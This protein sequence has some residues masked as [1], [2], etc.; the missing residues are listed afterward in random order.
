MRREHLGYP[1]HPNR[2]SAVTTA[3]Q[4][5]LDSLFPLVFATGR[6]RCHH[7]RRPG[8]ATTAGPN[9]KGRQSPQTE[10]TDTGED[11]CRRRVRL[12]LGRRSAL[13][14]GSWEKHHAVCR[15]PLQT[16][17]R[18]ACAPDVPLSTLAL[19]K[20]SSLSSRSETASSSASRQRPNTTNPSVVDIPRPLYQRI[21]R[22]AIDVL[23][24]DTPHSPPAITHIAPRLY[25]FLPRYRWGSRRPQD[26]GTTSWPQPTR[27]QRPRSAVPVHFSCLAQTLQPTRS[28]PLLPACLPKLKKAGL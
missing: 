20:T 10:N 12:Q 1:P 24:T 17:C 6:A 8:S 11:A 5:N 18:P 26:L 27:Q 28:L 7:A 21:N 3:T 9:M 22:H 15:R 2:L 16:R 19:W 13:R 23:R 4:G 14:L 25:L